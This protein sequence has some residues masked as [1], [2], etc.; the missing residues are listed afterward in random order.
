[1]EAKLCA[2]TYPQQ[3]EW[4]K[5]QW[6]GHRG[7]SSPVKTVFS[8]QRHPPPPSHHI[9]EQAAIINLKWSETRCLLQ[10]DTSRRHKYCHSDPW[11]CCLKSCPRRCPT[12]LDE[13]NIYSDQEVA[14]YLNHIICDTH[15]HR[16]HLQH[17]WRI[18]APR[19]ICECLCEYG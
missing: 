2:W 19:D 11:R 17:V 7:T 8:L 5:G 12:F 10:S 1:M 18:N 15:L 14:T 16:T 13:R 9:S 3:K 4:L 6:A